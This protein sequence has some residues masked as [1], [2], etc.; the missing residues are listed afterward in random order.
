QKTVI[1]KVKAHPTLVEAKAN[2]RYVEEGFPAYDYRTLVLEDY[3]EGGKKRS[4]IDQTMKDKVDKAYK[5]MNELV[6]LK[7]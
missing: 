4:T 1:K 2:G 6:N 7:W 5:E 3:I